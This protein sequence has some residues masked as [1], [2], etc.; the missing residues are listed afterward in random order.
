MHGSTVCQYFCLG[1][2]Q[3]YLKTECFHYKEAKSTYCSDSDVQNIYN[4][5]KCIS[6][7]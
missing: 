3:V 4:Y 1:R 5:L 2:Q 7:V 6:I